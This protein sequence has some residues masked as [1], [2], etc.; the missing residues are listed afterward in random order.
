MDLTRLRPTAS[1]L[2]S[3]ARKQERIS[4]SVT[5]LS[6]G[7][8]ACTLAATERDLG[9]TDLL[10]FP[11]IHSF[12]I[13]SYSLHRLLGVL[14]HATLPE[15]PDKATGCHS[16]RN[17]SGR[18]SPPCP[19]SSQGASSMMVYVDFAL[20]HAFCSG[21][22]QWKSKP[23]PGA[24]LEIGSCKGGLWVIPPIQSVY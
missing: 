12:A 19:R 3:K 10:R 18:P 2:S 15:N 14:L 5:R 6:T 13:L 20:W 9:W 21:T 8:V 22:W 24:R 1:F 17:R 4:R 23:V 11:L 7:I 16:V